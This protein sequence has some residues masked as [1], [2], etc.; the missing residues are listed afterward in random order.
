MSQAASATP[1][2]LVLL[3]DDQ[4]F[5]ADLISTSLQE[6][7]DIRVHYEPDA[8]RALRTAL[9]LRPAVVLVDL[10]MPLMD[11]YAVV[12]QFRAH[13]EMQHVPMILLSSNDT[14]QR[15]VQGFAEGA[16]DYLVKWPSMAE[17]VARVRYHAAAWH[18]RSER[19][20]AF[21]KLEQSRR[22][23]LARTEELAASRAALHHLQKMEA[24]GKLTGGVAHDFNN[25]LQIISGNL[26]L[27]RMETASQPRAQVRISSALEGVQR[28]AKLASQLLSFARRQPLQPEA[29][30]PAT[31]LARMEEMLR[32]TLGSNTDV[33]LNLCPDTGNIF[34]DPSQLENVLL[35]LAINGRDAMNGPG[36]L[37][38][39]TCNVGLDEPL[40]DSELAP[41]QYVRISVRDSGCGMPDHVLERV[42]EPFFTTKAPGQGTGLGLSMAYGFVRQSGGHIQIESRVGDGTTVHIWL[43]QTTLKAEGQSLPQPGTVQVGRA[44]TILVV[45]DEAEVRKTT[46]ELLRRLGYQILEA[47][48]ALAG[49]EI[50]NRGAQVDLLFTDVVMPG[51]L[52][53]MELARM[54][55]QLLPNIQVLF[56]SGYAHDAM[57]HSGGT[58]EAGV[59]LLSKPYTH[60]EL[61]TRI[62]HMLREAR[63]TGAVN[64]RRA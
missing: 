64:M 35:N 39:S 61:S 15:K 29:V 10:V 38:L 4:E 40:P 43:P 52:E 13:P 53:S 9:D 17:L 46:V 49:L 63:V 22:E 7:E 8:T 36:Q 50:L 1:S 33:T 42:F 54:A 26:Q 55:R 37:M 5:A 41:G 6:C 12:R 27:L 62:A 31:L 14:A 11:G 57:A 18:A 28:G 48:N 25:V 60:A 34:V 45:E 3:I 19:D 20:E 2:S 21:S 23:L 30:N 58:L 56:A 24:V 32:R 16:N 47:E 59:T 51:P 44:E